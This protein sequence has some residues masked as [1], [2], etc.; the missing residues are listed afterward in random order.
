VAFT[1][2]L[3]LDDETAAYLTRIAADQSRAPAELAAWIV[4][5]ELRR[6]RA[7]DADLAARLDG[8]AVDASE[9]PGGSPAGRWLTAAPTKRWSSCAP[10]SSPA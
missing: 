7:I 3:T 5:E 6:E 8:A 2:T 10:P 9:R 4:T 1:V